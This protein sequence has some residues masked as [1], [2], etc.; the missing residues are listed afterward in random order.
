V[1]TLM[2]ADQ[3]VVLDKGRVAEVGSWEELTS[4]PTRFRRLVESQA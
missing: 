1:R 2:I 4:A 3:I